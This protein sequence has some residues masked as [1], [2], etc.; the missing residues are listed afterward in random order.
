M[1]RKIIDE[2]ATELNVFQQ[3]I[4]RESIGF[5][6]S[7]GT[8]INSFEIAFDRLKA[9][10]SEYTFGNEADEIH[11]FKEIKPQL[12]CKLIYYRKIYNIE[13]IRPNGSDHAQ[14]N[15][16]ERELDSL[17]IFF[18][19]NIDFYKYYRSGSTYLDRHYFLRGKPDI[20]MTLESFY[21]E[22]DPKF[23]TACDFKVAKILANELLRIYLNEELLKLKQAQCP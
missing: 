12:F 20:Q 8:A 13:S 10:V 14:I 11:F 23:S 21:F 2:I 6:E 18:D 7:L 5:I 19:R 1:L 15:Y 16:I 4:D 3:K 22:R 17:K 9:F